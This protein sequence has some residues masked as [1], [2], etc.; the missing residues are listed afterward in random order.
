MTEN[1]KGYSFDQP[2]D[3]PRPRR[4]KGFVVPRNYWNRL[5]S[6]IERL[7]NAPKFFRMIGGVVMGIAGGGFL[8][9]IFA[10]SSNVQTC[11]LQ[12]V[13]SSA[14]VLIAI[15]AL[16]ADH[17]VHRARQ[18]TTEDILDECDFIE[19]CFTAEE[20]VP[21]VAAENG[22]PRPQIVGHWHLAYESDKR[23]GEEDVRITDAFAYYA[24]GKH[25]FDLRDIRCAPDNSAIQFVKVR[26]NGETEQVEYLRFYRDG[27]AMRGY[28]DGDETH[29]LKYRRVP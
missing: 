5:R 16:V 29:T 18:G 13:V 8:S 14:L 2:I 22:G 9:V 23:S 12:W 27:Q 3:V 7:G 11:V 28:A 10:P 21:D 6:K 20:A 1:E 25:K 24:D 4:Q 17:C 19:S 26:L 15:V